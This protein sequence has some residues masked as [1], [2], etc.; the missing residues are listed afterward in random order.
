MQRIAISL[1]LCQAFLLSCASARADDAGDG[2]PAKD[3]APVAASSGAGDYIGDCLSI[4]NPA[5]V[6][7]PSGNY[8]VS[9]QANLPSGDRNLTLLKARDDGWPLTCKPDGTSPAKPIVVAASQLMAAGATRTGWTYGALTMPYKYYPGT[10]TFSANAP[11]GAYVGLR[12]GQ[13]GSGHTYAF[14]LTL[15]SV[16]A[17]TI[18]PKTLVDGKPSVTG[19]TDVAALS[20]AAGMMFD[21]L[22]SSAGKP[23]KAGLFVGVDRVSRSPSV[24]YAQNGKAWLALQ[25]GYDFTDN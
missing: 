21:V 5:G 13:A 8:F 12:R 23:F 18:D 24:S 25:I 1:L 20:L 15:S 4:S 17:D 11:I 6:Q 19:T 16:K 7:P 14:A 9:T 2:T 10:K 22:K 3:T